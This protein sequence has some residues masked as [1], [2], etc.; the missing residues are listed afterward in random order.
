[1]YS[2]KKYLLHV[3]YFI[4]VKPETYL[5]KRHRKV[6]SEQGEEAHLRCLAVGAPI[7]KFVWS[8]EEGNNLSGGVSGMKFSSRTSQIDTVTWESVLTI[9]DIN[10]QDF[11]RYTC[12]GTNEMGNDTVH[13]AL[14]RKGK[15]ESHF[16]C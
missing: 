3:S 2:R 14:K 9:K 6:A 13:V 5:A 4:V 16:F 1:M 15:E 10:D 11:G 8:D 12:T 7:V